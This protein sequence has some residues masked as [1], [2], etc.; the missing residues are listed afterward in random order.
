MSMPWRGISTNSLVSPSRMTVEVPLQGTFQI[1]ISS[2][3]VAR[4]YDDDAPAGAFVGVS[5]LPPPEVLDHLR[6]ALAPTWERRRPGG[7]NARTDA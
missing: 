4:G 2:P 1:I 6:D 5:P 3:G 7:N